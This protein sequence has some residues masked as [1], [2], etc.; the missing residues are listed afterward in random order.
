V[1]VSILRKEHQHMSW[2]FRREVGGMSC[3]EHFGIHFLVFEGV[4]RVYITFRLPGRG[5]VI[6]VNTMHIVVVGF[7]G[8]KV[9][10]DGHK[11][12]SKAG[13]ERV[14]EGLE[15][16]RDGG[17][18]GGGSGIIHHA[19]LSLRRG[20]EGGFYWSE[21]LE[22]WGYRSWEGWALG[23]G[24]QGGRVQQLDNLSYR[25]GREGKEGGGW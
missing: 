1:E 15:L 14:G 21:G 25:G 13:L 20:V 4:A 12:G 7:E 16:V 6:L 10:G 19:S 8:V 24:V 2:E 22:V 3:L 18:E 9:A 5:T 23:G 17:T 11:Q